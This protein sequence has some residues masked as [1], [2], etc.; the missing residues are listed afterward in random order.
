M[1]MSDL[2]LSDYCCINT[3]REIMNLFEAMINCL[4][5]EGVGKTRDEYNA[6]VEQ[7]ATSRDTEMDAIAA[8]MQKN[9]LSTNDGGLA[10]RRKSASSGGRSMG[11][12]TPWNK[13]RRARSWAEGVMQRMGVEV[14]PVEGRAFDAAITDFA[15]K[16]YSG[17]PRLDR[18]DNFKPLDEYA[19][20]AAFKEY[21]RYIPDGSRWTGKV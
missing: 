16:H 4:L 3:G 12:A 20:V 7:A 13:G 17:R 5:N 9:Q 2:I 15:D 18:E 11:T 14:H 8:F 10:H 19:I 21:F 1:Y 6:S